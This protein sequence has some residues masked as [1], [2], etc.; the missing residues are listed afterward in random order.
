MVT[1]KEGQVYRTLVENSGLEHGLFGGCKVEKGV[2]F[3]ISHVDT[4]G[5]GWSDDPVFTFMD[6]H[7]QWCVLGPNE[8]GVS[9]ELVKDV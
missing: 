1:I 3:T 9:A 5:D 7:G 4:D 2:L 8:I 6:S